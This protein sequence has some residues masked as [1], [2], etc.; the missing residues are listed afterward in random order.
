MTTRT[1]TK[2]ETKTFPTSDPGDFVQV[3]TE[4]T[5]THFDFGPMTTV[6]VSMRGAGNEAGE[7]VEMM[8]RVE[9]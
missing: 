1:T 7:W 9:N 2:T 5:T 8:R 4:R 3:R 6:V